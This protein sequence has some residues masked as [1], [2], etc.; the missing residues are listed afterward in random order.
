MI[1]ADATSLVKIEDVRAFRIIVVSNDKRSVELL[2]PRSD[3]RLSRFQNIIFISS[4]SELMQI[5]LSSGSEKLVVF[6]DVTTNESLH[7]LKGMIYRAHAEKRGLLFAFTFGILSDDDFERLISA[8]FDDVFNLHDEDRR[9][10][11]RIY[12]WMRRFGASPLSQ[13]DANSFIGQKNKRIGKWTIIGGEKIAS[14]DS[15]RKV[16]LTQQEVDFLTL[17]FDSSSE[18]VQNGSYDKLF[19]APHAIVHKLKKKLGA[20]LPIQHEGG[21]QY[22]LST[23]VGASP[24]AD[25]R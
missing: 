13:Q 3:E 12:S 16:G 24:S 21:G 15:G 14:D 25:S 10:Y 1:V 23:D 2:L 22:Y 5:Y 18:S 11:L 4:F 20:E 9:K 17:L 19:K 6:V 8:G 7:E